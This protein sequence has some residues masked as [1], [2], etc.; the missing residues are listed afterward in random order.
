[1]STGRLP[2]VDGGIQPT[3]V[4]A[5]GDLIVATA[6]DT[7]SRLA[8]GSNDQVLTADSTT[9]TGLKWATAAAGG[10]TSLASGSL[11]ASATGF[12]LT[13]ISGSYNELWLYIT[14]YSTSTT[15]DI[16]IRTNG[17]TVGDYSYNYYETASAGWSYTQGDNRF[18]IADLPNATRTG[19]SAYIRFPNYANST[20]Y[21]HIFWQA[22]NEDNTLWNGFGFTRSVSAI[23]RITFSTTAGTFDSGTYALFGVK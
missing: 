1:M 2:S 15:A 12:D 17:N 21:K 3:I 20:G 22:A 7:V 10:M 6:A 23:N 14:N 5:K 18:L 16:Q 8:V 11:A 4:D 19:L 13:S 9:A